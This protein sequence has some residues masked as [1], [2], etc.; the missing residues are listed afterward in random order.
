MAALTFPTTEAPGHVRIALAGELDLSGAAKLASLREAGRRL[1]LVRG[2]EAVQ[3][4]FAV[5]GMEGRV[6]FVDDPA[7]LGGGPPA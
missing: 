6:Y 2:G 4:L 1:L 7:E 3:R 5:T